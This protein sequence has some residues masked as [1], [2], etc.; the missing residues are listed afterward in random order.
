LG[1]PLLPSNTLTNTVTM[2]LPGGIT[3]FLTGLIS[4]GVP[5]TVS[6][7]PA[8]QD[9]WRFQTAGGMFYQLPL[10]DN[11][12][13]V[14]GLDYSQTLHAETK[15]F[16]LQT[17]S[18]SGVLGARLTERIVASGYYQYQY[19]FLRG[20]TFANVNRFGQNTI[21]AVNDLW[22]VQTGMEYAQS[23]FQPA[24]FFDASSSSGRLEALRFLGAG[25]T[26]YLIG[27]YSFGKSDA[28]FN[29]FSYDANIVYGGGRWLLGP[30]LQNDVQLFSSLALLNFDNTDPVQA[31]VVRN[32]HNAAF[33][34]RFGRWLTPYANLFAQYTFANNNS[35]IVRQDFD[36]SFIS[37]GGVWIR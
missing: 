6:I 30:T 12:S 11:A 19:N 9:D 34:A 21:F 3:D 7:A 24:P 27:G 2:A 29:S 5:G 14:G 35:N 20:Q 8:F 31:G 25:R 16:D 32:D 15:Q 1:L 37:F 4:G 10:G 28:A 36:S 26:S 23:T 22:L 17:P 33:S 18:A 13:F